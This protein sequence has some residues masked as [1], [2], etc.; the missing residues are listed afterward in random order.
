MA[1]PSVFFKINSTDLTAAVDIQSYAVNREDVYESWDDGN[2]TTHR[3][4][5][6]TRYQGTFQ[7]GYASA[8]DFAAWMTLL[9]TA[10][11][12][13]G[14][15]PVTAYINNLGTTATFDAFLDVVNEEDRWDPVNSRQ[16][17]VSTVV[18][19]GR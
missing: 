12:A 14:Y 2:W 9:T 8:T 6:R 10:K 4:I 5:A 11:S 7:I 17:Q 3:Q 1:T 16:W 13:G 18:L 19:T 15:Y